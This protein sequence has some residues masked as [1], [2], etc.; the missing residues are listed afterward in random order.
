MPERRLSC[1]T[2]VNLPEAA[3]ILP[4]GPP[5]HPR[6]LILGLGLLGGSFGLAL[7]RAGRAGT[8]WGRDQDA[9]HQAQAL[10]LG[11]IDQAWQPTAPPEPFDLVFL[12]VPPGQV[13]AVLEGLGPWLRP[14]TLL[15][16]AC[17]VKAP[18][19]AAVEAALGGHAAFVPSHPIAGSHLSGP[20]AARGDL[21]EGATVI[22]TP[23]PGLTVQALRAAWAL[24][25]ALGARVRELAPEAHD[26]GLGLLSHLPQLLVFNYLD[27]VARTGTDLG[28]AGPGFRDFTRL[29]QSSPR[30]WAD[31]ALEN[32]PHLL[33]LLEALRGQLDT[34][35][36]NLEAE[37][38]EALLAGFQR[39]ADLRARWASLQP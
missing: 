25:E 30:L 2:D 37:D 1:P 8:L 11:L 15:L 12:G 22:I 29:A 3:P 33:P 19:I 21:F 5:S 14:D 16:D 9:G 7:R 20:Q 18:V 38:R 13:Q 6:V 31:I 4:A 26:Q 27:L 17:S 32:R 36:R 10:A 35:A 39:A 24:W 28:L 23:P 34:L